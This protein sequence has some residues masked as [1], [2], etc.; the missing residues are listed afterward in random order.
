MHAFQFE[1]VI[2]RLIFQMYH[3]KG[4]IDT[5]KP[6]LWLVTITTTTIT[7]CLIALGLLYIALVL[8][9]ELLVTFRI[10]TLNLLDAIFSSIIE[11]WKAFNSFLRALCDALREVWRHLTQEN[12]HFIV[13]L[14]ILVYALPEVL[15]VGLKKKVVIWGSS[16]TTFKE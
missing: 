1:E 15:N 7:R 8:C 9:Q 12:I 4:G 6:T 16:G 14:A 2:Y 3:D 11:L 10:I 13:A 5:N